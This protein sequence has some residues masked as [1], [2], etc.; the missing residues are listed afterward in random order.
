MRVPSPTLHLDCTQ[1]LAT[2]LS[3]GAAR[4]GIPPSADMLLGLSSHH[5]FVGHRARCTVKD[6]TPTQLLMRSWRRQMLTR[7]N[8]TQGADREGEDLSRERREKVQQTALFT[9]FWRDLD[10]RVSKFPICMDVPAVA[11]L[12]EFLAPDVRAMLEASPNLA[13]FV[14]ILAVRTRFID[15]LITS[16]P[17]QQLVLIGAGM[18]T[19]AYRLACPSTRIFE[20]DSSTGALEEKQRCLIDAGHSLTCG[21]LIIVGE[22]VRDAARVEQALLSGGFQMG[23]AT[24]WIFE[25]ILEYLPHAT[26]PALFAMAASMSSLSGSLLIAQVLEPE[27]NNKFLVEHDRA[28]LPY[29]ALYFASTAEASVQSSGWGD[30]YIWRSEDLYTIYPNALGRTLPPGFTIL[31]AKMIEEAS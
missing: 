12:D 11:I 1:P 19:R 27:I 22:D 17:P 30:T 2:Q 13:T 29:E 8:P 16:S 15:D 5:I 23:Q 20:I 31:T 18:D 24:T 10:Q 3:I 6:T 25:G 28:T 7:A 21:E 14:D 26:H 4:Q 9:S